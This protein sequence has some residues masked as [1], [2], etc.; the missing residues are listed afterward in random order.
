[1]SLSV[2]PP[3]SLCW[4]QT[5]RVAN[6]DLWSPPVTS[7]VLFPTFG[8]W[9][10]V[11]NYISGMLCTPRL[12]LCASLGPDWSSLLHLQIINLYLPS[13]TSSTTGCSGRPPGPA[14]ISP[15]TRAGGSA[16]SLWPHPMHSSEQLEGLWKNRNQIKLLLCLRPS[17][18]FLLN[19]KGWHPHPT[20]ASEASW[21]P[22]SAHPSDAISITLLR[23]LRSRLQ[24]TTCAPAIGTLHS[25]PLAWTLTAL[26]PGLFASLALGPPQRGFLVPPAQFWE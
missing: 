4:A 26:A 11:S 22:T 3:E 20:T 17:Y 10:E 21:D 18:D 25:P 9:A 8:S 14:S 13:Q 5:I 12:D 16:C 24:S 15:W 6:S 1:M 7:Q 23:L 2:Q 19:L